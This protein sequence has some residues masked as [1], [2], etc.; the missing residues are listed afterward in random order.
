MQ[1]EL[2]RA[3]EKLHAIDRL[4]NHMQKI[5]HT[6]SKNEIAYLIHRI[7]E[8]EYIDASIAREITAWSIQANA[9]LFMKV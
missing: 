2:S 1:I 3:Q 4:S 9:D 6:E 5:D 7:I 8:C